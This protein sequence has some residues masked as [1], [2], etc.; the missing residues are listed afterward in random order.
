MSNPEYTIKIDAREHKLIDLF[1]ALDPP[2]PYK[3]DNL[4]IGDIVFYRG[5][6]RVVVIERKALSDLASSINGERYR[7][8]KI[9]LK[10]LD[11]PVIYLIEGTEATLDDP[12]VQMDKLYSSWAG[13]MLRDKMYVL[14]AFDLAETCAL[15]VK[16]YSR[17]QEFKLGAPGV[18]AAPLDPQT[19]YLKTIK[20]N[21]KSNITPE[22]SFTLLLAQIPGISVTMA[23]KIRAE[24]P[25]MH[26]LI[27]HY[28]S[29]EPT[30][31]STALKDISLGARKLGKVASE[32]I[33]RHLYNITS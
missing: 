29:L 14:R 7:N 13:I 21:K 9:R 24:Y 1:G 15:V 18:N 23:E 3:T 27:M 20:L 5:D 22:N 4:D 17:A 6:E 32:K 28:E 31:R 12:R 26:R 33:Y 30:Q 19:E 2:I 10:T 11:C 16:L 8:Q 25:S